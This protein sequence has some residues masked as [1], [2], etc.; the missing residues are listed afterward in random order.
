MIKQI[1][2]AALFLGVT[3]VAGAQTAKKETQA[4]LRK[5]AKV[6]MT[7]ARATALKEVPNGR[8]SKSELEREGGKLIY[9]FDIKVAGKSGWEEINVDAATGA[10]ASREHETAKIEAKE[11]KAEKK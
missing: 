11:K 9:S 1:A 6:S 4:Q 10:I 5:E 3:T 8:V 2:V 7:T